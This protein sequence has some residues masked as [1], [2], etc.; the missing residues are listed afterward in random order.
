M[1][2]SQVGEGFVLMIA[3]Q[4]FILQRLLKVVLILSICN[5]RQSRNV[6]LKPFTSRLLARDEV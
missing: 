6:L 5:V 2:R 4:L 3:F 1:K